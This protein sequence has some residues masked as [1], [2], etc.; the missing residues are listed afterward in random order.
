MEGMTWESI[1]CPW[2]SLLCLLPGYHGWKSFLLCLSW[3]QTTW[4]GISD[5]GS[6]NKPLHPKLYA[7]GIFLVIGKHTIGILLKEDQDD[8]VLRFSDARVD[9]FSPN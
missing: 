4:I 8:K 5:T 3:S 7:S 9:D 1:S 6:Q 2:L